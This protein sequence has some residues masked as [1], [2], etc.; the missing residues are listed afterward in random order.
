MVDQLI[1]FEESLKES[2]LS[3]GKVSTSIINWLFI[4]HRR[5][6]EIYPKCLRCEDDLVPAISR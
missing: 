4:D 5:L 2:V 6:E 3:F 1:S